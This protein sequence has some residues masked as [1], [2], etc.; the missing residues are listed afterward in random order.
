MRVGARAGVAGAEAPLS[1]IHPQKSSIHA[2]Y[3]A[4]RIWRLISD[5]WVWYMES[6]GRSADIHA[7]MTA[8][9]AVAELFRRY[10]DDDERR[11]VL[12]DV[13][14]AELATEATPPGISA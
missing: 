14:I 3:S 6:M 9:E 5:L 2:V 4:A 7:G 12:V 1:R 13:I 11:G 8:D 10:G